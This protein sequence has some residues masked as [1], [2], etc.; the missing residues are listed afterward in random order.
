MA[1]IVQLTVAPSR[2]MYDAASAELGSTPPAGLI[3]HTATEAADGS[4]RI[5]DVWESRDA[6][7]AFGRNVLGPII[8]RQMEA[9][10][11]PADMTGP[12]PEFLEP[13]SVMR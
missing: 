3:V 7:E 11:L 12:E 6:A 1:E 9:A 2:E 10:G 5:I 8:V 13:F 4:V